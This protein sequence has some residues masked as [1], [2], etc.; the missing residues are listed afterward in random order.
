[1]TDV[2]QN[3]DDSLL[4]FGFDDASPAERRQLRPEVSR[5][6]RTLSAQGQPIPRKLRRIETACEQDAFDEMF[7]NMPV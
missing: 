4:E 2:R 6:I 3:W 1:M 5:I 7:D